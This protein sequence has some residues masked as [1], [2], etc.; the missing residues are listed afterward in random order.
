MI[1]TLFALAGVVVIFLLGP[2]TGPRGRQRMRYVM[3]VLPVAGMLVAFWALPFLLRLPYTTDMG[4]EKITQYQHNLFGL[5]PLW[6]NALALAGV[7]ASIAAR[8][9]TGLIVTGLGIVCAAGFLFAPQSRL[10]NA[11]VLPF[12]YLC[13]YLVA[14]VGIAIVAEAFGTLVARDPDKPWRL[15]GLAAPA[16]VLGIALLVVGLPLG[17]IPKGLP[18]VP[19]TKDSS[20]IPSWVKWNYSGY[21]R[22]AAYPEYSR[23]I[24]TMGKLPCGRAMWEY[25]PNLDRYGTPMAPMLLPYWTHGCIASM[26]GLFFE[27]ASSTPYHFLNQSELSKQPSRAERDL[28]YRNLDITHGIEHLQLLGVRYYMA[29]SPEALAQAHANPS[30]RLVAVSKPW[31][32]FGVSDSAEVAPLQYRPAVFKD[33]PKSARDWLDVA[34]NLYQSE[35]D[36]WAVPIAAAGPSNWQRIS[37]K[38]FDVGTNRTLGVD[39]QVQ[40]PLRIPVP[41][42]KVSGIRTGDDRISF[43]VDRPGSPVLVK[44]SY[45]PNWQASGAKGPWRVTPN[46]MV[47][48]PTSHHVSLHYGY[49][50]VERAGWAVTLLGVLLVIALARWGPV[51][52]PEPEVEAVA[53]PRERQLEFQLERV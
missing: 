8:N 27:S 18:F 11:R 45:F 40:Q 30:L 13:M 12:W 5:A 34:T 37:V 36:Q 51:P 50:A 21:E 3:T 48:I 29:F 25:E 14:G 9:R 41:P 33:P 26:E 1:P 47:V 16:G 17:V 53:E 28:P 32:I 39:V 42:T 44:A 24:S 15:P 20:F 23:L 10:W 31:E 38:K 43:D 22:K 6:L 7:V 52:M 35:P 49:T 4:W 19:E 46:L 2:L